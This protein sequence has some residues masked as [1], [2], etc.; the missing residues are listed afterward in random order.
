MSSAITCAEATRRWSKDSFAAA[1]AARLLNHTLI[2]NVTS[3][4]ISSHSTSWRLRLSARLKDVPES[5]QGHDRQAGI[6]KALA[7]PV[8]VNLHHVGSGAGVDGEDLLVELR[9]ADGL[10]GPQQERFEHGMFLRSQ[11][12]RVAC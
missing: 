9:L 8:D 1:R 12:Q 11:E 4:G 2:A 6:L 10:S 7:Q 3:N 5:P